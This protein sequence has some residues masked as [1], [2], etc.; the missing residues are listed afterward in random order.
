MNISQNI[1]KVLNINVNQVDTVLKLF[2]EEATIPF[3]ARYRKEHTGGLDEDQLREIEN[4]NNYLTLLEDRKAA[5]LKSIDEQGKLTDELKEKILAAD[6]L[7][8][9]EDLYLPYKPK[10]KTRGTIA[11]AKGLEPLANFIIDNPNF[12]GDFEKIAEQYINDEKEVLT[13]E[14]A[15]NGAK[16]IIAEMIS[17]NADVRKLVRESFLHSSN[18]CSTKVNKKTEE[19]SSKKK[20]VYDIYHDFKIEITRIKPYQVLAINR[21]EKEGFLKASFQFEKD[22]LL[23]KIYSENFSFKKSFFEELLQETVTDSFNRLIQPSIEREVRNHLTELADEHAVSVFGSNLKQLLLQPPISDKIIMGIDPG[24]VSGS[25]VAVID[26]TGK[27]LE[28]ATIYPHPPQNKSDSAIQTIL[29]LIE[30]YKVELIAIGNGTASRETELLI[31]TLIKDNNLKCHYLIVNEAG[32]SVYSA[33][34]VAKQEFPDLEASQRGNISIARRVLDPLAELVKIDSKS[35]G[36]GLYQHDVDQKMLNKNLDDVVVSCVNYVGVDLNTASASLLTY[37]S[38]L[39]KRIAT[40][41]VKYRE[42]NGRFNNRNQLKEVSGV[43]EKLFEQAAGFLK[44]TNGNNPLDSTFIHPESYEAVEKLLNMCEISSTAINEKGLLVKQF[45]DKKNINKIAEELNVGLPTLEDIVENIVKPGRDPREDMPKPI[46]RSDV[47]K[48]EDL[49]V[50]MTLKGTVRNV[51][52]FGAFVD[53]GVKQ[54]GLLHIS[55]MANKFIKHPMEIVSVGDIVDVKIKSVD[56][57][58][59]RIAL[60]MK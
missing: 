46:L 15:I 19:T 57:P 52:D 42:Q 25:K 29:K 10:R 56:I 11:K 7:Q 9:V 41:I 18:I 32:A 44:I 16:D 27:Y 20:D 23:N 58:K 43:G 47:L 60:S 54:D 35:I 38:G 26:K 34:P 24:F 39:S 3:I 31:S 14:D 4:L 28:G 33:S 2:S 48:I 6:K 51:V 13:V 45:V 37:V 36:V 22:D 17:E 21:G 30:K 55:E 5:V 12:N 40:N 49:E 50:G 59:A 8:D 53:I 1:A